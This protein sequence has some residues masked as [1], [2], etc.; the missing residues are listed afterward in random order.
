MPPPTERLLSAEEVIEAYVVVLGRE[1]ESDAV[2]A[3]QAAAHPSRSSLYRSL[4]ESPEFRAR[5]GGPSLRAA[6]HEVMF[7]PPP[8]VEHDA[9]PRQLA[10]MLA[11][12][13][14]QWTA[15]GEAEPYWSVLTAERFRVSAI[16]DAG[17]L[18]D[19]RAT[20][21][22][23][24]G[25]IDVF[26]ART[27]VSPRGGLCVELGCGVGR[28]TRHL[29]ERFDRVIGLDISPGNLARCEAYMAEAGVTNVQTRPIRAMDDFSA[30]DGSDFFYSIISLQHSP[31]PL[32]KA[33]L[34]R[35]MQGLRPGGIML[36]QFLGEWLGYEFDV[37]AYVDAPSG[38]MEMHCLPRAVV[39]AEMAA[40]GVRP[41]DMV[42]DART[43]ALVGSVTVYAM[44]A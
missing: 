35:A 12:V 26:A 10:Q 8:R 5:F 34:R 23:E 3:R 15:L 17:N 9:D 14:D 4:I 33:I 11:R 30:F 36:I 2:V 42:A 25:L 20:G 29:A 37:A 7:A 19:F 24:A 31:P 40:Q 18:D 22:R 1:P 38:G 32:Q 43:A 13:R 16:H 6:L 27:G 39:L 44:K 28:V 21:L 41:L